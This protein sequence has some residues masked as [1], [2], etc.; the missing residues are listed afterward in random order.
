VTA[1]LFSVASSVP[2]I[3][4]GGALLFEGLCLRE[5]DEALDAALQRAEGRLRADGGAGDAAQRSAS[6]V[7]AMYRKVGLDPTRRRPSSE[8]LLRRV[9]KGEPFPRVNT[10]VD[11][12]NWCSAEFQLPYGAYDAD[13][14]DGDVELRLGRE[15]EDYAGIRKDLVHVAARLVVADR[16]GAFGN[17]T[18]DSARTMVTAA[19]VRALVVVYAPADLP[20]AAVEEALSVTAGRVLEHA[21]GRLVARL[22]V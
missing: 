16:L 14:I 11:V 19:T 15:G 5:E 18:S 6:A 1:A 12:C 9:L 3:V 17:P 10:L 13:R 20:P 7:R 8:A 2:G 4:R 22:V 21:A